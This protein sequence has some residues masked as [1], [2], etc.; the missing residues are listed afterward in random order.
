MV[1][2]IPL[3]ISNCQNNQPGSFQTDAV[4]PIVVKPLISQGTNKL[5]MNKAY[6]K[7]VIF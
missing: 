3:K 2:E 4:S 5:V 6:M 1:P 7:T